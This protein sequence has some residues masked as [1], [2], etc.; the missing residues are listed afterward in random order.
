MATR[1]IVAAVL[2]AVSFMATGGQA[3]EP[4]APLAIPEIP[5]P[6]LDGLLDDAGWQQAAILDRFYAPGSDAPISNTTVRLA[7]DRQWLYLAAD[8][9]NPRMGQVRQ[10]VFQRDGAVFTDDSISL[11][12]RPDPKTQALYEFALSFANVQYDKRF[13]ADGA[14]EDAWSAPWRSAARTDDAG[15]TGELAIP[16]FVFET[17]DL[18]GL[19]MNLARSLME[20][21]LDDM[22]AFESDRRVIAWSRPNVTGSVAPGGFLETTG[23][24]GF[25]PEVP[26]LPRIAAA[27]ATGYARDN[28]ALQYGVEADLDTGS[29]VPGEAVLRVSERRGA[30]LEAVEAARTEPLSLTGGA[31]RVVRVA[32]PVTDFGDRAVTVRLVEPARPAN[33]LAACDLDAGALQVIR[34]AVVGRSYVTTEPMPLRLEFG[35]SEALLRDMTLALEVNGQ[36][37]FERRGL[38]PALDLEIPLASLKEGDNAL[39]VRLLADGRVLAARDLTARRLAPRPGYEVKLDYLKGCMLKDGQPHFPVALFA[40]FL[41]PQPV[42]EG[43][44]D[45][46]EPVFKFLG[47]DIGLTCLVRTHGA[48]HL[49]RFMDLAAAN[50]LDVITWSYPKPEDLRSRILGGQDPV[51]ATGPDAMPLAAKRKIWRGWYE[52]LEPAAIAET[53]LL[54]ERRN[55]I[56]YYNQDEPNLPPRDY[57]LAQAESYWK[58]VTAIDPYRPLMLLFA[59]EIPAGDEWTRW[60]EI[61]GYDVYPSPHSGGHI[62]NEPGAGTAFYAAEL[63]ERCRRDNK[64][65]WFVPL[66]SLIN[67]GKQPIGMGRNHMLCQAYAAIVYGVRGFLYFGLSNVVGPEAWDAL[68][69]ICAQVKALS[70]ALLNGDIPQ[71]VRY[72]GEECRPLERKFPR[73]NAAVFRY[74]DGGYLLLAVNVRDVAAR[75]EFQVAGATRAER[76]FERPGALDCREATFTDTLEGYGVRAYR[77]ALDGAPDPVRVTVTATALPDQ[78]ALR[79]DVPG[80]IARV[81]MGKN[82]LPNPCF[83]QQANPGIP[84]FYKPMEPTPD[85]GRPGSRWFVDAAAPW[86][87]SPSLYLGKKM[88][89]MCYPP[90][91]AKPTRVT[92]SLYARGAQPGAGVSVALLGAK[93]A[94]KSF[95]ITTNWARYQ[96]AFDV[97]ATQDTRGWLFVMGA[98]GAAWI[99]GLQI[100]QGDAATPFQDDSQAEPRAV[101]DP[102]NRLANGGA[103]TGTAAGWSGLSRIYPGVDPGV[104]RG[105]AHGGDYAFY[106]H[107]QSGSIRSDPVAV[108]RSKDGVLTGYFKAESPASN[109]ADRVRV[110]FG[111]VPEPDA[112]RRAL[113]DGRLKPNPK[114]GRW[115]GFVARDVLPGD[116]TALTL[117]IPPATWWPGVDRV[118]VL[119]S[120]KPAGGAAGLWIDDLALRVAPPV[121]SLD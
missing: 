78:R 27:R 118:Q 59:R 5:A 67:P 98:K 4:P 55:L 26:F 36:P 76:L 95:A 44:A 91:L 72:P 17:D 75:T 113:A 70:P 86:E 20:V 32:V 121:A 22:N 39:R 64:I 68:R 87:G 107:G 54:R 81:M 46:A 19:R 88:M 33:V 61:L 117:S 115:I 34:R 21:K 96:G 94:S 85:D 35:L 2:A 79:V 69:T 71:E 53:R 23:L 92:F 77:L 7:R 50:G 18:A 47:K 114:R 45:P 60:G 9:R 15:W 37:A 51:F 8:C 43:V 24:G 83:R 119:I 41:Y 110:M 73:V 82:H 63:R 93:P 101:A 108:D 13:R 89:G 105:G 90:P 49:D 66:A 112:E 38:T 30:G 42:Q 52:K 97:R 120:P 56:G 102:G 14:R 84:D 80:I 11:Y 65:M 106:W 111:L 58:T 74:P 16:L 10:R 99:N 28:G 25:K 40:H 29:P 103:E 1:A 116:W 62:Y 12:V 31:A 100:E 57:R 6:V 3:A 104:R 109:A 48:E